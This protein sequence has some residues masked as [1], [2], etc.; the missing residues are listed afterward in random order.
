MYMFRASNKLEMSKQHCKDFYKLLGHT[1]TNLYKYDFKETDRLC[2][3]AELS[4][5]CCGN[6]SIALCTLYIVHFALYIVHA[7]FTT[8]P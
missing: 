5:Q 2:K 7:Q 1:N 8:A 4:M 3:V 6:L